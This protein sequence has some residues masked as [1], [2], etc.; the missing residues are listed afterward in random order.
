MNKLFYLIL[1]VVLIINLSTAQNLETYSSLEIGYDVSKDLPEGV[2]LGVNGQVYIQS[3]ANYDSTDPDNYNPTGGTEVRT[4]KTEYA[5]DFLLWVEKGVL[6]EDLALGGRDIWLADY[7][8]DPDYKL[9]SL[10]EI[11]EYIKE[12]KHL[13]GVIGQAELDKKGYYRIN[14][15]LIGQLKNLEEVI[16]HTIEQEKKIE[17]QAQ[18]NEELKALVIALESRLQKQIEKKKD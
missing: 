7:V 6:S 16:L 13:P 15:M 14:E 12:H 9:T 4:I 17:E 3:G 11:K 8:F 2:V 1:C 5:D 18:Q 10:E